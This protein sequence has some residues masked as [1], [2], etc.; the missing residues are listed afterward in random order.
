LE[1]ATAASDDAEGPL[2]QLGAALD[3]TPE[4]VELGVT[5]RNLLAQAAATADQLV[6]ATG[7][8]G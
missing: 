8:Q 5:L 6:A 4:A 7:P 2:A 1:I 3:V